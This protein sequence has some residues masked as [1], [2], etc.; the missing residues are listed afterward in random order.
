MM[1]AGRAEFH[2]R[3]AFFHQ[4]Q[5]D[6][7]RGQVG[8][9]PT[10]VER[11]VFHGLVGEL[12]QLL[13]IGAFDPARGVHGD[14]L[15]RALHLVFLFQAAGDHIEL[16]HTDGEEYDVVAA[17]EKHLKICLLESLQ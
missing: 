5:V 14:R 1:L 17:L 4:R 16:Q 13:L 12:F 15:V 3:P 8:Q 6:A 10:A 7:G 11:E 2:V 9:V